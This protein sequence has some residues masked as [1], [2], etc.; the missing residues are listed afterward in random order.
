[1]HNIKELIIWRKS[2][3]LAKLVYKLSLSL[4][5]DEKYGLTSQIKRSAISI[6]SN[7]A[8]GAGRES[9]KYFSQFLSIANGSSY[10]LQTQ[11]ILAR[12]LELL[13]EESIVP[14]LNLLDEVIRINYTLQKKFKFK[15]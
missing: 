1:M 12:E 7:V 13:N 11:L 15:S 14:S 9:D 6:P 8:E 5:D 10:E 3:E 4:P 2:I